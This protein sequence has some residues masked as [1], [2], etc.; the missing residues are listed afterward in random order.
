[1]RKLIQGMLVV[2]AFVVLQASPAQATIDQ[3][4]GPPGEL[5]PP[6]AGCGK[7]FSYPIRQGKTTIIT[8]N[9]Q[10][11]DLSTGLEVDGSGV[12]VSS[13]AGTTSSNKKVSVA[14]SADAAPGVRTIKLHYLVELNGPDTFK[15]LV[16]RAG[17]VTSVSVP[18]PTEFFND[19]DVTLHGE[20]LDNAGVFVVPTTVGTF[21]MGSG[22]V[23]QGPITLT[24]TD[25]T[26][27]ILTQS[28]TA[29][30]VR[31]HFIGGPF[32]ESKAT[33]V[34]FDK[35][36][37]D[38][39]CKTHP[40]FCYAGIDNDKGENSFH[41]IGP[42]AVS[43]ITF[44]QGSSVRVGSNLTIKITLVRPAKF[45]PKSFSPT[46]IGRSISN[47]GEV[48][49]WQVVPSDSFEEAAGSGTRFSPTGDNPR[50]DNTVTIPA[51]DQSI[52]LTIRLKKTPSSCPEAG[53]NAQV[54]TRMGN[55]NTDQPPFL[56][57]TT[58]T[59]LPATQ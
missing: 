17:K 37:N 21:S 27:T 31:V 52:L 48:V 55:F 10:F 7:D 49:S 12:T 50:G 9:G 23:P 26:A 6:S 30:V 15:I 24:Q 43:S 2:S 59:M 34:L 28:A 58:F 54:R 4:I 51:G 57:I 39:V 16:L 1:M 38:D 42:N 11:V 14:V 47:S 8:V 3:I 46:L 13:A 56:R 45:A 40:P 32:A 20:K 25:A 41:V 36:L 29:P 19:V 44:P 5:C 35:Q 33:L 22:Q 53:C 18:S